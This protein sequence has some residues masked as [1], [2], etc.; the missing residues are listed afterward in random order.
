LSHI[1][2]IPS[3]EFVP[4]RNHLSGIFQLHQARALKAAGFQVGG[5]SISLAFSIP[6]IARGIVNRAIGRRS[7]NVL[8][9]YSVTAMLR[10]LRRK[11]TS[12][13]TFIESDEVEGVPIVRIEGF[14]Y[15]PPSP[16]TNHFG[17]I[18]AGLAAFDEYCRLYGKPD[19]IHAHNLDSAGM[20]A[21]A[22]WKRRGVPFVVTEH[23]TY[24]GLN[25]IPRFLHPRLRRA[26]HAS[27]GIAAVSPALAEKLRTELSLESIQILPNVLDADLVTRQLASGR[28][29]NR[30]FTFLSIGNL[31]AVKDHAS[32]LRAFK[33]AFPENGGVEL[34]IAGD[35][36]LRDE[37]QV[38]AKELDI[39]SRVQFLGTLSRED[40]IEELDRCDA[41][42]LPSTYET[43]G[44]V[45]IEA[46]ARG[47]PVVATICGGPEAF[48]TKEDGI[49]VPASNVS[50]LASAMI[51]LKANRR[52]YDDLS[53]KERAISR[54][55]P[56]AFVDS[57]KKFY[58]PAGVL[59]ER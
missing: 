57:L 30:A 8:D 49:L 45:V 12:A 9:T 59:N 42:V 10:L 38:L 6:M 54:F 7:H 39:E 5:I 29:A 21:H 18:R 31:I 47:K 14:Y 3:E 52:E 36:P 2:I 32:L 19:L 50:E 25:L 35:G 44:V 26:A 51:R 58:R 27:S 53:I 24:F 48:V 33:T 40:V 11:I 22:I 28:P 20:L 55:G 43:F 46:L 37:L 17:W 23:S 56:D 1:L 13:N 15:L 16:Y 41:F 34:R 4:R